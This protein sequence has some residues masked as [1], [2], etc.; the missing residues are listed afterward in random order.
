MAKEYAAILVE[1]TILQKF[2]S[3]VAK[4]GK[5]MKEEVEEFMKN[6]K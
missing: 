2:K 6:Y 1:K 4:K 5:S 3:K